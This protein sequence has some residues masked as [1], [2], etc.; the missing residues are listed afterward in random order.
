MTASSEVSLI[1][2]RAETIACEEDVECSDGGRE[3]SG[4]SDDVVQDGKVSFGQVAWIY[5]KLLIKLL[6]ESAGAP[7]IERFLLEIGLH[8][9]HVPANNLVAAAF[10]ARLG[11]MG[12]AKAGEA[13][14]A[15]PLA[16]DEAF[17]LM[18]RLCEVLRAGRVSPVRRAGVTP[19]LFRAWFARA[20]SAERAQQLFAEVM[21][22]GALAETQKMYIL[23]ELARGEVLSIA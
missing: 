23:R 10:R 12:A 1:V 9:A 4:E 20:P 8:L 5:L 18:Q 6:L 22:L 3:Q 17:A 2:S 11:A 14:G 21:A 7:L 15:V 13:T 16:E 19:L